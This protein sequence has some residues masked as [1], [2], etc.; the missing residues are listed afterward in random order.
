MPLLPA[1]HFSFRSGTTPPSPLP[2]PGTHLLV[3]DTLAA[4]AD[5]IIYHVVLEFLRSG[6]PTSSD[7]LRPVLIADF[8]GG[9][10]ST[11]H[12]EAI[13]KKLGSPVPLKQSDS[14]SII[15]PSAH[16]FPSANTNA[17]SL[18]TDADEPTLQAV[19]QSIAERISAN[20]TGLVVLDDLSELLLLGFPAHEV[21]KFV[22]SLL[23]LARKH[24]TILLT[25]IHTD[26]LT[27]A[28]AT[29]SL[30]HTP[31]PD[32]D[33]LLRLMRLGGGVWWRIEGLKTGRS[34]VVTGEISSHPLVPLP[35]DTTTLASCSVPTIPRS[36]PL[37]YR[38]DD[39][40]VKT[41]AKGT[42][43]GYL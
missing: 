37:Q 38:M 15:T 13:G 19:Y 41:F 8:S 3:T 5:F 27:S 9:R 12:W 39:S 4:S 20:G 18:Y 24:Q 25:H 29:Q 7:P 34:G 42:G 26:S 32:L 35:L 11:A 1:S 22:R 33:L 30:P 36:K 17:P 21:S 6:R 14:F 2:S 31:T 43:E 28:N 10:K 16:T 23:A 40:G